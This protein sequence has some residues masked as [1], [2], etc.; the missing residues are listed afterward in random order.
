ML[1]GFSLSAAVWR[2][3]LC[4]PALAGLRLVAPDLRGHGRSGEAGAGGFGREPWASDVKLVLAELGLSDV[5]AV[6]WSMGALVLGAYLES[7]R[8]SPIV[9]VSLVAP[10]VRS[11]PDLPRDDLGAS[12]ADPG[13]V[14]DS[15]SV[16]IPALVEFVRACAAPTVLSAMDEALLLG[17]SLRA[18]PATRA[19]LLA[20]VMD[21]RRLWEELDLPLEVTYGLVDEITAPQAS[22]RVATSHPGCGVHVYDSSGHMP[23][24]SDPDRFSRELLELV[25]RTR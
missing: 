15:T 6:A 3:Q 24:W 19:A 20:L 22:A 21:H 8:T 13:L 1:H 2:R 12:G 18:T 14:A 7:G 17:A 16:A 10:G 25:A 4:D 11:V 23:F 5:I 9:A